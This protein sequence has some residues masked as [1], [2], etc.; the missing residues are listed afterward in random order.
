MREEEHEGYLDPKGEATVDE[1]AIDGV[2]RRQS[3]EQYLQVLADACQRVDQLYFNVPTVT[4]ITDAREFLTVSRYRERVYCYELYHHQ[5][6]LL[7]ESGLHEQHLLLNAETDKSGTV[8]S[9][10]I[11]RRKP[12]FILHRPGEGTHNIAITEVKP[13]TGPISEIEA[14]LRKLKRFLKPRPMN[15]F[16][17]VSLIYGDDAGAMEAIRGRLRTW[18]G[19]YWPVRFKALWHRTPG[20]RPLL[21]DATTGVFREMA[22]A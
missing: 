1:R 2:P 12:D 17:A 16:G 13:S 20:S 15:Y 9:R 18:F 5:R 11:G 19:R 10:W 21:W 22:F 14:D 8:Y 7:E 6:R 4:E 3:F